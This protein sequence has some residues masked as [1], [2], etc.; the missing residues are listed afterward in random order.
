M[1]C[2]TRRAAYGKECRG[3]F[4]FYLSLCHISGDSH[5]RVCSQ[6]ATMAFIDVVWWCFFCCRSGFER[7]G[8]GTRW[9]LRTRA[10]Y[11]QQWY[12]LSDTLGKP[13]IQLPK[14]EFSPICL[15]MLPAGSPFLSLNR[16]SHYTLLQTHS[17]QQLQRHGRICRPQKVRRLTRGASPI[18]R[19]DVPPYCRDGEGHVYR[20]VN[21]LAG[22][23]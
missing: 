10:M 4:G 2:R 13:G 23:E 14:Q 16:H 9:L 21:H 7:F 18:F 12:Y 20:Y 5:C 15:Q 1:P 22:A 11:A 6:A 19:P 3:T 17:N 8:R